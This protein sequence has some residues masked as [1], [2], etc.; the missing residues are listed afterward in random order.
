M[1]AIVC[2]KRS[3]FEDIESAASASPPAYKKFRCASTTSPVR[4]ACSPPVHPSPVDQLRALFPDM[5]I[6]LL[7]KVFE[8]SGSDLESAINNLNQLHLGDSKCDTGLAVE[9][10]V[11][12]GKVPSEEAQVR[13]NLPIGGAEWVEYIVN[14]ISASSSVDDARTRTAQVLENLEKS[15]SVRA[16]FEV[17]EG[18]HKENQMLKEQIDT[19][20]QE[21]GILKRAVA[22]QHERHKEY[23]EKNQEALQLKE[24]AAQCQ[25]QLRTLSANNYALTLRLQ[26]AQLS[27]ATPGRFNPDV[28]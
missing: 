16:S 26:Q 24:L 5:E 12:V 7:E 25:E 8:E 20:L 14:Q 3:F 13:N 6:K 21:N 9:T 1:S 10:N 19:L 27:N 11:H 15:I 23:D 28:F 4:F 22:I 18:F 17:A 2:G